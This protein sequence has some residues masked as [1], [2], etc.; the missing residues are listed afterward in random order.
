MKS[1][2]RE[3]NRLFA[4]IK[5]DLPV[6]LGENLSGAYVYGS[7]SF[8]SFD[9]SRSDIDC[10]VVT[11]KPLTNREI[12]ALRKWH[13]KLRKTHSP[14]GK[15]EMP[16]VVKG[17]LFLAASEF[18]ETPLYSSG[19]FFEKAD[20]NGYNPITWLNIRENGITLCG[21]EPKTF[22]PKIGKQVLKDALS[23]E[24]DYI[25]NKNRR[26]FRK[27]AYKSYAVLTLCRILY[28][29][30]FNRLSSKETAARWC[31]K[32]APSRWHAL[33]S[34]ALSDPARLARKDIEA[35]VD[36]VSRSLE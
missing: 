23:L 25:R 4:S 15:L 31:L 34:A 18:L 6:I 19:R 16:Y 35:F 30:R 33:I 21:A 10:V 5:N 29:L 26:W 7:V 36:F 32:T 13:G 22:V 9:P 3:I 20:T 8:G 12:A 27:D 28:T 11:E 2:P 17:E 1:P 24:I 14:A